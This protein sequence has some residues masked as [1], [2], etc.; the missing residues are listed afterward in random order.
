MNDAE[1]VRRLE[2]FSHLPGN[3]KRLVHRNRACAMRS[4]S[5]ERST[6][7]ITRAFTPSVLEPVDRG[8]VRI[9]ARED[10]RFALKARQAVGVGCERRGEDLDRDLTLQL[11]V[12]RPIDLPHSTH[13]DAR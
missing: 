5:V 11:R 3:G 4:G 2:R 6:S 7:S 9:I 10:L 8:D 12:R 1:L 13:A